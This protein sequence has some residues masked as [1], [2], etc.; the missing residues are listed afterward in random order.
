MSHAQCGFTLRACISRQ[1]VRPDNGRQ[2]LVCKGLLKRNNFLQAWCQAGIA[3]EMH[4]KKRCKSVHTRKGKRIQQ[5]LRSL[6]HVARNVSFPSTDSGLSHYCAPNFFVQGT[7]SRASFR[8]VRPI[9]SRRH[10]CDGGPNRASLSALRRNVKCRFRDRRGA[11]RARTSRDPGHSSRA[12][13]RRSVGA[14]HRNRRR[15]V[16]RMQTLCRAR[17]ARTASDRV[18]Q[19]GRPEYGRNA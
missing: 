3:L 14:R 16:R 18:A 17:R 6:A 7:A 4:L 2:T 15:T 9:A 12:C 8:G 13:H 10:R 11:F 19:S 5:G 1:P